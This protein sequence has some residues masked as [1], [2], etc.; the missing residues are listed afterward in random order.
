ME[1]LKGKTDRRYTKSIQSCDATIPIG[2]SKILM[3][4]LPRRCSGKSAEKTEGSLRHQFLEKSRQSA[5]NG[6]FPINPFAD[7]GPAIPPGRRA[8]PT[9]RGRY[10]GG[11]LSWAVTPALF[12]GG[13]G[14]TPCGAACGAARSGRPVRGGSRCA[15]ARSKTEKT[16]WDTALPQPC[17][18]SFFIL[19][20]AKKRGGPGRCARSRPYSTSVIQPCGAGSRPYW[21]PVRVS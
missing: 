14:R 20:P 5:D 19:A 18:R 21:M 15:G 13:A 6:E 10:S 12:C 17:P 11:R 16:T 3:R 7:G 2:R 9:R 8:A 4:R 1:V